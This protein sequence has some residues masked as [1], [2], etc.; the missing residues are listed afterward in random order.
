MNMD[1]LAAEEVDFDMR[2][3]CILTEHPGLPF[4]EAQ[5]LAHQEIQEERIMDQKVEI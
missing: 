5:R 1:D 2:V 3:L 4:D